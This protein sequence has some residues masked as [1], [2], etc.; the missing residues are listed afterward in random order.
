MKHLQ[1]AHKDLFNQIL[2]DQRQNQAQYEASSSNTTCN[3]I[4]IHDNK[5]LP[6]EPKIPDEY[7]TLDK[8]E[9][10]DENDI[11]DEQIAKLSD[12]EVYKF[13]YKCIE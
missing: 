12:E 10:V 3:Q 9:I 7:V 4:V 5:M 1:S 2:N 6:I 13:L 8:H 11:L